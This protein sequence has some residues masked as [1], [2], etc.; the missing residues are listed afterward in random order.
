MERAPNGRL[1]KITEYVGQEVESVAVITYDDS[2]DS[3]S[4]IKSFKMYWDETLADLY[5]EYLF[6]YDDDNLRIEENIT[7]NCR[8]SMAKNGIVRIRCSLPALRSSE[9]PSAMRSQA[10]TITFIASTIQTNNSLL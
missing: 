3:R 9:Q 10:E 7:T 6:T 8:P 2:D 5:E 4:R 1:V